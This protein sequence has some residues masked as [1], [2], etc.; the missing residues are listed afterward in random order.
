MAHTTPRSGVSVLRVPRA[1]TVD[2]IAIELRKAIFEGA[3]PVGSQLGEVEI[4][5]QLGVSRSPLR[6]AAQRLVQEGLLTATPGRG[7]RVSTI[8]P[9][10]VADLYTERLAVET[11]AMR[12]IV[13]HARPLSPLHTAL[14]F[15]KEVSEGDDAR[16]IGD[17]DL[18]FHRLLVSLSDSPRLM[19]AMERLVVET[20]IASYSMPQG[21]VVRRSVSPTYDALMT[22]LESGQV[23]AAVDALATQFT[24]AITRLTG[25]DITT[26]TIAS[27]LA[28]PPQS[29]DPIGLPEQE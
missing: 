29:L 17:A 20:R 12:D 14:T 3:L 9:E 25:R 21:Y 2:L 4:S 22:H 15:L 23:A 28:D 27:P 1:S 7:L 13:R 19:K 16:A 24:E 8:G 11:Q 26:D 18:E 10:A 5:A 6:E